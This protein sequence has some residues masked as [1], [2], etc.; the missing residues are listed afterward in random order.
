MPLDLSVDKIDSKTAVVILNGPLTL[1]T[2]L[3]IAE[4]RV[5][6]LVSEGITRL[7]LDLSGCPYCDSAGLGMLVLLSGT[8]QSSNGAFRLCGLNGRISELLKLTKT[9]AILRC[10]A[11]RDASLAASV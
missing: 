5:R 3:Q 8:L 6:Q 4:A 9:D 10:D 2:N 1:G 11:D 7:V